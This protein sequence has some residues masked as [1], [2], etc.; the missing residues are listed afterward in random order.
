MLS[1][2]YSLR[3]SAHTCSPLIRIGITFFIFA[4]L[5]TITATKTYAQAT[6][7]RIYSYSCGNLSSGHCYAYM[8]WPG[9][10]QGEKTDIKIQPITCANSCSSN[11]FL[12]YEFW[13][14]QGSEYWVEAG[15]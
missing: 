14:G 9:G 15:I 3:Y 6:S 13:V 12:N 10:M 1:A 2:K 5:L 7:Q 11:G 8:D 4:S